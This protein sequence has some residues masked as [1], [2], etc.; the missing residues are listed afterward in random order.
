MSRPHPHSPAAAR[1]MT[2][3]HRSSILA[4]R[5]FVL[6]LGMLFFAS[7]LGYIAIRTGFF[8]R[9]EVPLGTL[10]RTFPPSLWVS[11]AL[12]LAAS[13]TISRSLSA[14]RRERQRPFRF[15]LA[16]TLVLAVLFVIVQAPSLAAILAAHFE[17]LRAAGDGRPM[18]LFGLVFFLIVVHALHVVGGII[19]L[20]WVLYRAG[21]N[22]YDH[23]HHIPVRHAALYWH[24]LDVVWIALFGTMF[25][26]G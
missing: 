16:A 19:F 1:G 6:S 25:V 3:P 9:H 12:V 8:G 21:Q 22:A 14:V 10:R 5:L 24:F 23:E 20:A 13:L 2:L 26:L 4:M 17:Q 7:M 11:T 15:W 18:A